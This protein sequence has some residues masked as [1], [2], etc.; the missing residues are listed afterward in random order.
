MIGARRLERLYGKDKIVELY[1]NTVPFGENVYGIEA[2]AERYYSKHA[3]EL[4]IGES[5]ALVGMLKA[6]TYYSPRLYPERCKER[7]S[8]VLALMQN[9]GHLALE[10]V[11][12]IEKHEFKIDYNPQRSQPGRTAL[13]AA[14][15]S[16]S[17]PLA[18][19]RNQ[20]QRRPL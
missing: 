4:T 1:L 11:D 2:A 20:T 12:S 13:F 15:S 17:Q 3:S 6:N 9:S 18:R 19:W 10:Q 7:R 8:V 16:G 14:N 5:S